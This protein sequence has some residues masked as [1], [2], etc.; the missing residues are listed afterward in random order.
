MTDVTKHHGT[1]FESVTYNNVGIAHF[2]E[3]DLST[4]WPREFERAQSALGL[5]NLK[6]LAGVL[7]TELKSKIANSKR[8]PLFRK[9]CL[10]DQNTG[11]LSKAGLYTAALMLGIDVDGLRD[12]CEQNETDTQETPKPVE[13]SKPVEPVDMA[14]AQQD[15]EKQI[16]TLRPFI[17]DRA[18]QGLEGAIKQYTKSASISVLK[19]ETI[20]Q[21]ANAPQSGFIG[22]VAPAKP[23][24]VKPASEVFEV[25]KPDFEKLMVNVWDAKDAP[26]LDQNLVYVP[27]ILHDILVTVKRGR[28]VLLTGPAGTGK[29]SLPRQIAAAMGR[30]FTRISHDRNTE[31]LELIGGRFPSKDGGTEWKDG[32]LTEAIRKA[33]NIIL[34]DEPTFCRAG[35]LAVYQTLLDHRT[36]TIKETG[37][38]VRCANG[39]TFIIADNTNG[40]GDETGRYTDT[41]IMNAA[42][43]DRA[44]KSIKIDYLPAR[45]ERKALRNHTGAPVELVKVLVDFAK[46]TR[47]AANQDDLT[48]GLSFRRLIE[49]TFDLMDGVEPARAFDNCI[50]NLMTPDDAQSITEIAKTYLDFK[51]LTDLAAGKTPIADRSKAGQAFEPVN[52]ETL[53]QGA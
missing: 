21:S 34:L 28:T 4:D 7:R 40:T 52:P 43:L 30:P 1:N 19:A 33:G 3:N 38:V 15:L 50:I 29:T 25:F 6:P 36:L 44:A 20:A 26:E 53:E 35:V 23:V 32:V 49:F 37:E 16:D 47:T 18:L 31:P 11:H 39:V 46:R 8:W 10:H 14:Q 17:A 5:T 9:W 13:T 41:N 2:K 45:L 27:E 42:F 12:Y 48:M 24:D 22:P 51:I